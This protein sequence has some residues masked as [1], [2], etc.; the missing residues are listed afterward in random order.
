MNEN[1]NFKN[2]DFKSWE[3]FYSYLKNKKNI[4]E[5][6]ISLSKKYISDLMKEFNL[7]D[8]C[9]SLGT[10]KI[11]TYYVPQKETFGNVRFNQEEI[12]IAIKYTGIEGIKPKYVSGNYCM[13]RIKIHS[14]KEYLNQKELIFKLAK[15]AFLLIE[16]DQSDY[17]KELCSKIKRKE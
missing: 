3:E 16:N 10:S 8:S 9:F 15:S 1:S 11:L 17:I 14:Q 4:G 12:K 6:S 13:Q 7:D 2:R 5:N